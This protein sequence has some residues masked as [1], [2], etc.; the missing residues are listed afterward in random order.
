MLTPAQADTLTFSGTSIPLRGCQIVAI[1]KGRVTYTDARGQRLQRNLDQISQLGFAG[2][3][4]LD[5]A[6]EAI[7]AGDYPQGTR[8]L[9]KAMLE[10]TSDMQRLWLHARLARVHEL[11]GQ[12]V[13][14][15]GHVARLLVLD[16]GTNWLVL[17]P[18]SEADAPSPA[19]L[20]EAYDALVQADRRVRQPQLAEVIDRLMTKVEPLWAALPPGTASGPATISGLTRQQILDAFSSEAAPDSTSLIEAP[21]DAPSLPAADDDAES[22]DA[23]LEARRFT[24]ALALCERLEA[25]PDDRSLSRFLY[26]YGRALLGVD[27]PRDAAIMF[28]RC[29]ILYPRSTFAV[30]CLI[31]A[32]IVHRD[33]VGDRAAAR[34]L[35]EHAAVVAEAQGR[36]EAA[37][38]ARALR[39]ELDTTRG[40]VSLRLRIPFAYT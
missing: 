14:A 21:I 32:A 10:A 24:E 31:D 22:L 2:L 17:E 27:R 9:L 8:W 36:P 35:L 37:Q 38:R 20:R 29:A 33:L 5:R 7:T 1:Q 6:E 13:A 4:S 3:E 18:T 16:D 11:Q 28:M 15:A 12:F 30:D 34:R 39:D 40:G 26:Q 25:A 23:L 19:T